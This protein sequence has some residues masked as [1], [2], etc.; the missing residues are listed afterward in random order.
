MRPGV[1]SK[2]IFQLS[3]SNFL[4]NDL[5]IISNEAYKLLINDS[6][7]VVLDN[8]IILKSSENLAYSTYISLNCENSYEASYPFQFKVTYLNDRTEGISI[9]YN[10]ATIYINTEKISINTDILMNNMP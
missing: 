10:N 1:F 9:K 5:F 8:E 7:L 2:I 3:P 6:N 4:N